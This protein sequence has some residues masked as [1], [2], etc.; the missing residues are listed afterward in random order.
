MSCKITFYWRD[1]GI[2]LLAFWLFT[3]PVLAQ[4]RALIRFADTGN[5]GKRFCWDSESGAITQ[6]IEVIASPGG[7]GVGKYQ[8][9]WGDGTVTA[10]TGTGE[11]LYTKVYNLTSFKN[12]CAS[13]LLEYNIII[14][15]TDDNCIDINIARLSINKV[16]IA[17][18]TVT[19]ACEDK[20][21]TF[22]NNSCGRTGQTLTWNWEFSNGRT[23]Q[24]Q[25]IGG[26]MFTDP[27]LDYW[28]RLT[29]RSDVCGTSSTS[30][31]EYFNLK[32]LPTTRAG[33]TN[34][35]SQVLCLDEEGDSTL[36]LDASGSLVTT[37][38]PW[39]ISGGAYSIQELVRR[40][41]SVIRIKIKEA[42]NYT[43]SF[44]A[45][46][47]CGNAPQTFSHTFEALPA[48]TLNLI[49]QA[50]GCEELNYQLVDGTAGA[51]YTLNEVPIGLNEERILGVSEMPYIV[52]GEI[53]NA[54]GV[55]MEADTFYVHSKTPVEITSLPNDTTLCFGT[56]PIELKATRQGG[57]WSTESI[58]N[59]G[60][61]AVFFP[62]QVGE[63]VVT[64][65]VGTGLC[66]SS[67]TKN[68]KV[69]N[70][71]A[72]ASIGLDGL[73]TGCSP[74]SIIFSNRSE[75]HDQG[76][77]LWDFG[78]GSPEVETRQD[79]IS[80]IFS[81]A[82][83]EAV[84][85]VTMKVRN[86]CG[87]AENRR[88]VRILPNTIKPLFE[89]SQEQICPNA[90]MIFTDATVPSPTNWL[91]YFGDGTRSN[92]P[93]PVH[94][95]TA[96]GT[97]RVTLVA[98]NQCA[99]DSVTHMVSVV[100]PPEPSFSVTSER[101]CEGEEIQFANQTDTRY[102]FLWEFGDAGASDSL[103]FE[104]AYIYSSNG[105]YNV[106]LTIFD[107]SKA[108]ATSKEL[109]ITVLPMLKADFSVVVDEEAC[110][111]ALVKFENHTLAADTWQWEF[112]DGTTTRTSQ[113]KE[114]L[115]P[116]TRGNYTFHLTASREGACSS[117]ESKSAY[118]DFTSCVVEVPEAFTPN[119]DLHGDRYTLFGN[120]IDR[121]LYMRIRNR[122]GEV[123]YEMKDVPA[124]SQSDGEA[125]DGTKGGRPLPADM[126]VFEAKVRYRDQTESDVVRGNFYLVR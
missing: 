50:D 16:P 21:S 2:F 115:I 41:S 15:S 59:V 90:D 1:Y 73:D 47:E 70:E 72:R 95:Y 13:G 44:T 75:G 64:Y 79:T 106:K 68:V 52:K 10:V 8:I 66:L 39:R 23:F 49:P 6:T 63:F 71:L 100:A 5:A 38:Y 32:K 124:G 113:V 19:A 117:E 26:Q 99:T 58:R 45:A 96:P 37:K 86:A 24:T 18:P 7:C 12:N 109:P 104:P 103:N 74:T 51:V 40:D 36:L 69:I 111:P 77:V 67:S 88:N 62:S 48:P 33:I 81:A 107:G 61:N 35:D 65:N 120:G 83:D 3:Q 82:G 9:A 76:F 87:L 31:P 43:I 80:H 116:F 85:T 118:F 89:L 91:W 46:N 42:A 55:K 108:C 110:E 101:L 122:W 119:G 30:E 60:G 114:P 112:S 102:G 53:S 20:A 29:V 22:T 92:L 28:V 4:D 105:I 121:I 97:Y 98:G 17:R 84:Y 94:Q 14:S 123:V 56:Q 27:S 11:R 25:N 125:W 126:Y 57:E 34:F 54:C 93:D 78:D